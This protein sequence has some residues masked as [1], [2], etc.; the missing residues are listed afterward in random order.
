MK[1]RR[2]ASWTQHVNQPPVMASVL[3]D[4][5]FRTPPVLGYGVVHVWRC[6]AARRRGVLRA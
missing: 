1:P 6:V 5:S 2:Q 4:P 3:P